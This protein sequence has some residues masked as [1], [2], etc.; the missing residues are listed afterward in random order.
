MLLEWLKDLNWPGADVIANYLTA[1]SAE[2]REPIRDVLR[3]GD[4]I[5]IRWT[6]LKFADEV[7]RDFWQELGND[8]KHVAFKDDDEGANV[9]ALYIL[10]KEKLI[11]PD[12][13]MT[14]IK[15]LEQQMM[16]DQ[17]DRK[18]IEEAIGGMGKI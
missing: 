11:S 14:R 5:W 15:I 13:I 7:E 18:K 6:L 1:F 10:A 12:S 3:S 17:T 8:L 2:L 4:N 16:I 9:E